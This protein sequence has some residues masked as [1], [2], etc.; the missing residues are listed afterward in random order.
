MLALQTGTVLC[1]GKYV[2]PFVHAVIS[3][4]LAIVTDSQKPRSQTTNL[5]M[6]LCYGGQIGAKCKILIFSCVR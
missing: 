5:T 2:K 4:S 1:L 3:R 6:L